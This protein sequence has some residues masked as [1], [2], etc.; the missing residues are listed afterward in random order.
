MVYDPFDAAMNPPERPQTSRWFGQFFRDVWPCVLTKGVGKEP[1]DA[2]VHDESKATT[3]IDLELQPLSDYNVGFTIERNLV[4]FEAGWTKVTLPSIKALGVDI[5][6]L[7]E[8]WVAVELKPTGETYV[9]NRSETVNKTSMEL[10]AVFESEAACREAYQLFNDVAA[11]SEPEPSN[12]N[13][14]ERAAAAQFLGPVWAACGKDLT[15]F[16]EKLATMAPLNQFFTLESP[17]V[18]EVIAS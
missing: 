6:D 16:Q 4:V 11:E 9:N 5:R 2:Q 15:A 14:K 13:S 10:V 7:H 1:Y 18:Q 12:G 8:A 3:A 17:E